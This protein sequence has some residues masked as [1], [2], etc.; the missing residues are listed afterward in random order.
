MLTADTH[1][2]SLSLLERDLS[3]LDVAFVTRD[4]DR[5]LCWEVPL[6]LLDPHAHLVPRLHVGN[7]I[8]Y[9]GTLRA[10]VIDLIERVISLLTSC[11][12]DVEGALLPSAH[13]HLLRETARVDRADLLLIEVAPA[14]PEGERGLPHTR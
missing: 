7:I 14:K 13:L 2:V 4:D 8:H 6:Q 10:L 12:P 9:Q 1:R 5:R 3:I 11:V